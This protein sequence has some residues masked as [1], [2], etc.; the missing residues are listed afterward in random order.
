MNQ[1]TA[2]PLDSGTGLFSFTPA[3]GVSR[4]A[5]AL[6]QQGRLV[7]DQFFRSLTLSEPVVAAFRNL[8][9]ARANASIDSWDGEGGRRINFRAYENARSFLRALPRLIPVPEISVDPDG[10]VAIEWSF[11]PRAILTV[12]VGHDGRVSYAALMGMARARGTEWL[13]DEVPKPIL[14]LLGRIVASHQRTHDRT[15]RNTADFSFS[16]QR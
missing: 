4:E 9:L 1:A 6:I 11:G 10:E 2:R 14:D 7:E 5:K 3:T 15:P 12:S 8:E 16:A 13:V